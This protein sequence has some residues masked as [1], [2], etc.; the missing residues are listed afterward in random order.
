M[1]TLREAQLN[2]A[3]H[4]TRED[5]AAARQEIK[6]L[7][8]KLDALARRL[9]GKSSEQLNAAQLELLL[10]GMEEIAVVEATASVAAE[11]LPE[12]DVPPPRARERSARVPEHLPLKE[13]IIDPEEVKAC[14]EEWTCIGEEVSEVLDYQP[15][16]FTRLRTIRRKYVHRERRHQPPV[17]APLPPTLQERCI[18]APSLLAHAMVSRYRDHLPWYR[19]EGIYAGLGV[20]ISRQTLCNWSGMAADASQLVVKEIAQSVFADGCVQIDETPIDYLV[21]GHGQTKTGYLWVAH[22]PQRQE[23]LFTWHTS[24]ATACLE[25]L[26]PTDFRGVI[27]CDGYQAY[28]AFAQNNERA[29]AITLAG[30]WAHA[31]RKFFEA[32]DHTADA[33]WVL[34]QIQALYR[35]EEQLRE[36]RAGPAERKS[37][38]HAQSRPVIEGIHQ[39]LSQWDRNHEHFPR[40]L[41]GQA[42]GYAL[43]QW[44]SLLVFLDDGRVEIDN[45][46]VENAIRPSAIGKKN[47]LFIG[48]AAAGARAA[49]FYTLVGNCRAQSADVYA[50]LKDLFTRLPVMTNQ[51][52]KDITPTAWARQQASAQALLRTAALN[53]AS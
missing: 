5:L 34:S 17:I 31:R 9:F 38:R 53:F 33:A 23:T 43:G 36:A 46:L 15:G 41:M 32:K 11:A 37:A 12:N 49:T 4:R 20:G 48:D 30:C 42:I 28:D 10:D 2:D 13:V 25:S 45:N 24:R 27:Q 19:I 3:L 1:E 18:A 21:P 44:E 51:Q 8:Q 6:L 29:G 14:P 39:R 16:S 47:W 7:R 40:S 22:N 52:I 26:V 50:Y 35:V